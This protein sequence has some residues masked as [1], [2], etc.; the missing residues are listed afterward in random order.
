MSIYDVT[1]SKFGTQMLPPDKRGRFMRAYVACVL[2]PMQWIN[3]LFREYRKGS[4]APPY[5]TSTTY[6][7]YERV[8]YRYAVYESLQSGN[9]NNDPLNTAWWMKVQDNFIGVDERIKYSGHKLNL[10]YALNRYFGTTFRQPPNQSDIYIITHPKPASVFIV[11]ADDDNS[12]IV[13]ATTSSEFVLNEY[14]FSDFI[15]MTIRVPQAVYDALDIDPANREAIV[16]NFADRYVVAGIIY[17]VE[18]YN[19]I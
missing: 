19:P 12:S 8:V 13:F 9:L 11:G 14:S 4:T 18:T 17:N 7:I 2:T 5:L 15:N 1:F 16:R 6:A 10:E 3:D